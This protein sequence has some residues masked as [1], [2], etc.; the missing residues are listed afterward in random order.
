IWI[1][2]KITANL[3]TLI[4]FLA[5]ISIL[6]GLEYF[7]IFS[8]TELTGNF[9]NLILI[10]PYLGLVFL[11]VILIL[12]YVNFKLFNENLYLDAYLKNDSEK[13]ND[14]DFSWTQRFG[15]SAPFMQLDLKLIWRN[16]RAINTVLISFAFLLYRLLIYPTPA[17][18]SG[19]PMLEFVRIFITRIFA[20]NFG[21]FIPAWD[22]SYYSMI[23]SQNIPMRL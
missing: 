5:I 4:P 10:H 12:Y 15:K 7:D 6:Y 2:K 22:S 16:I 19:H 14:S 8:I 11:P 20:I 18:E 13:F 23:M 21:Q 17:F 9:F 3:K 1:Q